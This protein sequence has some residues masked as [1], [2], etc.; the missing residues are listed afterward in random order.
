MSDLLSLFFLLQL[1]FAL[2]NPSDARIE[3]SAIGIGLFVLVSAIV[4]LAGLRAA[5]HIGIESQLKRIVSIGFTFPAA[6][7]GGCVFCFVMTA[8][9]EHTSVPMAWLWIGVLVVL[10]LLVSKSVKWVIRDS[11]MFAEQ[12]GSSSN[13]S[14]S[15]IESEDG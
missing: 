5:N 12:C 8:M 6:I 2:I 3:V 9:L 15:G 14:S 10:T 13:R 11:T 7:V 4:W 1:P